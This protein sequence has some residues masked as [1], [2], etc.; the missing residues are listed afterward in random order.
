MFFNRL[1]TNLSSK[2]ALVY[3]EGKISYGELLNT[4]KQRATYFQTHRGDYLLS[5]TD[6]IENLLN[7]LALMFTGQKGVFI[8]KNTSPEL[9]I[10]Y[11]EKYKL[12]VIDF[13]PESTDLSENAYE[14]K[15]NDYF[16]G[17][18][19][20]GSTGT[21]KL[22]WKD[23]QAWFSAFE[24]QSEVFNMNPDDRVM[25]VD[26]L[27]YSANLNTVIH[28]LW[29]GA[30]VVFTALNE[31]KSWPSVITQESVSSIFLVP[32]HY[33]LLPDSITFPK[34]SS[35]VS[36]G[37]KLNA[38][39]AKKLIKTFP[40]ACL[41]EYYGA[42]EL[43]HISYIQNQE[44]ID[45]PTS[46]GKAFPGVNISIK[47]DKIWVNS[48]YVSPEYRD[49]PT[50]LDIGY[51]DTNDY[52]CLLGRE[53]R[54][55]NRRGLNIFAEEIENVALCHPAISEAV[56]IQSQKNQEHLNLL[57][58]REAP[59]SNQELNTFLLTKV[60]KEKLP[61]RIYF[62]AD[63]PRNQSGKVDFNVLAKRPVEEE[64][65]RI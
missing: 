54:M 44:I 39:L 55:F 36:A 19:T 9:K 63:I 47:E 42:A 51:L 56:L 25:V 61:N 4:V 18:L 45:K 16:L 58:V 65:N 26:A 31:A 41:T 34:V 11:A 14:P 5:H 20:S 32:S 10:S 62:V 59:I 2:P 15:L 12:S 24:A 53:G 21:F 46:V 64:S 13:I 6:E 49:K 8:G 29:L 35:L 38:H 27:A 17:V 52:L 40:E 30:T 23:Y 60:A 57:L 50:V 48:P 28:S 33:R 7:F 37:E 3:K 22:I 43:G 1:H